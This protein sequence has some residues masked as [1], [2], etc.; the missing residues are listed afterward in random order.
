MRG[1]QSGSMFGR[2]CSMRLVLLVFLLS[3]CVE[4]LVPTTLDSLLIRSDNEW[5][6]RSTA[7]GG[8]MQPLQLA[9]LMQVRHF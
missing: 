2:T 3:V 1:A 8:D 6:R 9:L 4:S 7:D 5:N